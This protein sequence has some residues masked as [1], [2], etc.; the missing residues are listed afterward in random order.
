MHKTLTVR[1]N[2]LFMLLWGLLIT[3]CLFIGTMPPLQIIFLFVLM[4]L[5]VGL[6]QSLAIRSSPD[7]FLATKTA[8]DVKRALLSAPFGKMSFGVH[9]L[10]VLALLG[11]VWFSEESVSLK[12]FFTSYFALLFARELASFPGV[13]FLARHHSAP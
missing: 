12:T 4:G 3:A 2:S 6:F 10:A 8:T 7:A 11:L 13:L 5:G 9:W 1:T